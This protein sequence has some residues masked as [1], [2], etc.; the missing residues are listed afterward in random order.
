MYSMGETACVL[1]DSC[2]S[3]QRLQDSINNRK[4]QKEQRL[5]KVLI[6]VRKDLKMHK[7]RYISHTTEQCA[8]GFDLKLM[9]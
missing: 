8:N 6:Y 2:E 4:L 3:L 9:S 5:G 1:N 7:R